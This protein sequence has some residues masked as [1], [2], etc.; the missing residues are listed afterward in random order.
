MRRDGVNVCSCDGKAIGRTTLVIISWQDDT[1]SN[2]S[3][4]DYQCGNCLSLTCPT[5]LLLTAETQQPIV[6]KSPVF[7]LLQ[8]KT[9]RKCGRKYQMVLQEHYKSKAEL[10]VQIPQNKMIQLL[11]V[12]FIENVVY[13]STEL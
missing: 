5:W 12:S 6:L 4:C 8:V 7:I 1:V 11:I 2:G 3:L 10:K 9:E 13:E